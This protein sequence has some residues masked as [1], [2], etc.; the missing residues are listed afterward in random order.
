M[1]PEDV[2]RVIELRELSLSMRDSARVMADAITTGTSRMADAME[3]SARET[4]QGMGFEGAA[5]WFAIGCVAIGVGL[6]ARA[7]VDFLVWRDRGAS[8]G[9]ARAEPSERSE[10]TEA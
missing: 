10:D 4:T 1:L 9:G 6:V 8:D 3:N 2:Y 7:Y 5:R